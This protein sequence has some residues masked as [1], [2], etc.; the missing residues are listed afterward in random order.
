MFSSDYKYFVNQWSDR[1]TPF[2]YSIYSNSGKKTVSLITND[3]LKKKLAEYNLPSK[4]FLALKLP[5]A[6]SLMV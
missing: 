6:S 2:E 4:E 5:K 3:E 1:N